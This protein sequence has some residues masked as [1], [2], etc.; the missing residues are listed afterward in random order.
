MD[1][2]IRDYY[3]AHISVPI[4]F[5]VV[6]AICIGAFFLT[7]IFSRDN[8]FAAGIIVSAFL[9]GV[10]IW[11]AVDVFF[12]APHKFRRDMEK[13]PES[14]REIIVSGYDKA[15]KIG[16]RRFYKDGFLLF[17]SYRRIVVLRYDEIVSAEPKSSRGENIF[18]KLSDGRTV[19]MPVLPNEN[20]AVLLAALLEQAPE[21][22][23]YIN[24][25]LMNDEQPDAD[26]KDNNAE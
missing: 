23:I 24:G 20:G 14:D 3:K 11:A 13:M 8:T 26:G 6:T 5:A 15:A 18:L 7:G 16:A 19:L 22:K 4:R 2:I 10:F 12:I 1:K 9:V 25:R 21:I 17:Y